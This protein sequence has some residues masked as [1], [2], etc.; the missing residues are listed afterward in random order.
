MNNLHF[1]NE[2]NTCVFEWN[3]WNEKWCLNATRIII[4]KIFVWCLCDYVCV[5][6]TCM[7]LSDYDTMWYLFDVWVVLVWFMLLWYLYGIIWYL[8]DAIWYQCDTCMIHVWILYDTCM[9]LY[10]TCMMLVWY[11]YDAC[12]ILV[13]CLYDACMILYDSCMIFV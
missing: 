1:N 2:I 12:M 3:I 13:W 5:Y 6:D 7:I 9:R 11:L 4:C 8:Y 10:D